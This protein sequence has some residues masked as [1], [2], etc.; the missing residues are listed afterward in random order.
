MR[1]LENYFDI[2]NSIFFKI[3]KSIN[4]N[5]NPQQLLDGP[6]CIKGIRSNY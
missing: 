6:A 4:D 3:K 2:L 5:V 1:I